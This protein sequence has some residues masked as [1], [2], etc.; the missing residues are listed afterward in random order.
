MCYENRT[1]REK[2]T[3]PS[4][5]LIPSHVSLKSRNSQNVFAKF[6]VIQRSTIDQ[7]R[8]QNQVTQKL[9]YLI[10]DT[11]SLYSFWSRR[12]QTVTPYT[13]SYFNGTGRNLRNES[14]E[15]KI[16]LQYKSVSVMAQSK[17]STAFCCSKMVFGSHSGHAYVRVSFFFLPFMC[18]RVLHDRQNFQKSVKKKY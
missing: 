16:N 1:K 13:Q 11:F 18:L 4:F 15:R 14:N 5:S 9:P 3:G 10:G 6:R 7:S 2:E 12:V 17:V 8:S